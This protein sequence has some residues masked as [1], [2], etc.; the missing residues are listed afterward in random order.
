MQAYTQYPNE[1]VHDY[2]NWLQIVFKEN[3]GLLSD[4][5]PTQAGFNSMFISGLKQDHSLLAIR[6]KMEGEMFIPDLINPANQ[7]S[8]TLEESAKMETAKI[9]YLQLEQ[10]KPPK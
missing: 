6:T 4:V 7:L 2:S 3:P 8:H 9:L 10:M 1:S 5:N